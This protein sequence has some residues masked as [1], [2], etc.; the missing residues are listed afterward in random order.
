MSDFII[1]SYDKFKDLSL[2]ATDNTYGI[3]SGI[4]T[5]VI[6]QTLEKVAQVLPNDNVSSYFALDKKKL[7]SD[8]ETAGD[9]FDYGEY[10]E[11]EN[12]ARV[13]ISPAHQSVFNQY[14]LKALNK[15]DEICLAK[16]V[17]T[18]IVLGTRGYPTIYEHY[19]LYHEK[20]GSIIDVLNWVLDIPT[21]YEKIDIIRDIKKTDE[22]TKIRGNPY[23]PNTYS[24]DQ[25]PAILWL[26]VRSVFIKGIERESNES[27][28]QYI[29]R[30]FRLHK[31]SDGLTRKEA[32]GKAY[33]IAIGTLQKRGY[34]KKGKRE[35]TKKGMEQGLYLI[36]TLGYDEIE[37]RFDEFETILNQ[38]QGKRNVNY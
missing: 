31:V 15:E 10:L 14:L 5:A 20:D 26:A 13:M 29:S 38:A 12:L 23:D 18:S 8:K 3:G 28:K 32:V 22:W 17:C 25:T 30:L 34:L 24:S 16:T 1:D 35:A 9:S 6:I 36:D 27:T 7:D 19:F 2:M 11:Q 37:R 21:E 4:I 33:A